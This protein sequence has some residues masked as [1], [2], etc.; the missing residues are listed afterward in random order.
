MSKH[1]FLVSYVLNNQPMHEELH[2]SDERMSVEFAR[3]ALEAKHEG[4]SPMNISDIE[5]SKITRT[6]EKGETPAHYKQP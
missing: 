6:H 2:S 3:A 5:V 1:L 4:E